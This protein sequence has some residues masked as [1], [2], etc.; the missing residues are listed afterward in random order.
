[1]EETCGKVHNTA[2]CPSKDR[3]EK[4]DKILIE[5][6]EETVGGQTHGTFYPM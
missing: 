4:G 3:C 2:E 1:M 6:T 5:I